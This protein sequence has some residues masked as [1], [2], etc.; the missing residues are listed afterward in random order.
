MYQGLLQELEKEN[1]EGIK[2]LIQIERELKKLP[3]GRLSICIA[4]KK[5]VQ[6]YAVRKK[7]DRLTSKYIP[8]K[9]IKFAAQLAQKAYNIKLREVLLRRRKILTQALRVLKECDPAEVFER[10]H[11]ERKKL[12]TPLVPTEEM[13]ISKWYEEHPGETNSIP[14][15]TAYTTERGESVRSKSEKLI[16]DAYYAA[17]VPYVYEPSIILSN[18]RRRTPDFA[19]YNVRLQKTVYHEHFGLM[20][21]GDYRQG[22]ILKMREYSAS[23]Y[24]AGESIFY[25]FEGENTPFDQGELQRLIEAYLR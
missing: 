19:A 13:L 7:D 25:T 8:K 15:T 23:G 6:F 1:S 22:A 5:Y 4:K 11:E 21:D 18:G 2:M 24:M 12:I 10:E 20:D 14:M 17:R 9:K 16:A 3:E